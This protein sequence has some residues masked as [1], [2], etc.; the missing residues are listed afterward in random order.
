MRSS[1][2]FTPTLAVPLLVFAVV[3]GVLSFAN[4]SSDDRFAEGADPGA[5]ELGVSPRD[6]A[7]LIESLQR[8]VA[9]NPADAA[10][11][12]QLGDAYLQRARETG[13]TAL[14]ERAER[15]IEEAL[16]RDPNEL[17][18]VIGAGT[19]ALA[20]HDFREGLRLGERAR[21]LAPTAVR[22]YAV[23]VDAQIE[24]GR[25]SDAQRSLQAMVNSKP[26]LAS[27]SRVSYYRQ[28]T[29]DLDGAVEAMKLAV[30]ASGDSG[31]SATYVHS[32]LGELNIDRG[33]YRQARDSFLAALAIDPGYLPAREGIAHLDA[34]SGR[35][36]R[37]LRS[38][39]EILAE[40]P[41]PAY[42]LAM[43]DVENAAGRSAAAQRHVELAGREIER[44]R[45]SGVKADAGFVL[46]EANYGNPP[47]A[48]ELGRRI[49]RTAPSVDSADA[50]AWALHQAGR[51]A[52]AMRLSNQA[53]RLG[54]KDPS[55][56]FNAAIIARAAGRVGQARE[57]LDHVVEQ[58][59]RFSAVSGP[60][61]ER[62]LAQLR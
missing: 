61:A 6:T 5:G 51:D 56:L 27:Y 37:A 19:L 4:R 59:P 28:L 29:G 36:D 15:A 48:V 45:A 22:P 55:F 2:R 47:Q 3:L 13:G 44:L 54:S 14:Y 20:R 46:F 21:R 24:L 26:N 25:Y 18:A 12:A 62:L 16:Q 42:A 52:A 35:V 57:Y 17:T 43:S 30:S 11:Y 10:A 60:R 1:H 53:M 31:E 49:W 40:Q 8:S 32:L 50:Y 39:R 9:A 23:I 41:L 7:E 38:Y 33:H 58:S 34:T